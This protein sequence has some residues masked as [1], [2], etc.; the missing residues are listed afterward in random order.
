M[1]GSSYTTRSIFS[2]LWLLLERTCHMF[3]ASVVV[4]GRPR[5][6]PLRHSVDIFADTGP[7]HALDD[8]STSGFTPMVPF[9]A[10]K[11]AGDE[12][13]CVKSDGC[14]LGLVREASGAGSPCRG[15]AREASFAGGH[16]AAGDG[17]KLKSAFSCLCLV[18]LTAA[19]RRVA[20]AR[21]SYDC[22]ITGAKASHSSFIVATWPFLNLPL[23]PSRWPER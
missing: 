8:S 14:T 10:S 13:T 16:R 7:A 1:Q 12:C 23:F 22:F 2:L 9:C 3:F 11:R 4:K 18:R 15:Q 6:W 19:T 20:A 5:S 21:V 17:A